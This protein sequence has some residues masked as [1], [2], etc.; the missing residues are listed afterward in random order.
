M[1]RTQIEFPAGRM[2]SNAKLSTAKQ[3]RAKLFNLV[4]LLKLLNLLSLLSLPIN[5]VTDPPINLVTDSPIT[6]VTY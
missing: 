1:V 6:L 2:H 4:D 5:L 3:S